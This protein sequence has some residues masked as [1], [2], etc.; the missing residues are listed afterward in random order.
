QSYPQVGLR[1]VIGG[2][3]PVEW[4]GREGANLR[5]RLTLAA[6]TGHRPRDP[7]PATSTRYSSSARRQAPGLMPTVR[8]KTRVRW[9]WSEKPQVKA[10]S[11]NDNRPSRSFSLATST[12]CLKSQWCGAA[13]IVRRNEREKWLTDK[14]HSLATAVSGTR[15]SRLALRISLARLA[16][17]AA[18][19]PRIGQDSG[20][21]PP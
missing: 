21:K 5:D 20:R 1:R 15:P 11:N 13:P 17:H 4:R 2:A 14:P 7:E 3:A 9:L 12:R 18:S 8:V 16:C 19:P 10:T 6:K